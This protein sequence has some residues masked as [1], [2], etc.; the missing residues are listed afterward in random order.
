MVLSLGTGACRPRTSPSAPP[1]DG[2][3]C[4]AAPLEVAGPR[5][6]AALI[7]LRAR[8]LVALDAGAWHHA[9]RAFI[10]LL[11]A[12]PDDLSA[13][14]L[15]DAAT[16]AMLADQQ[17]SAAA[18]ATATA[19]VVPAPPDAAVVVRPAPVAGRGRAPRPALL[20]TTPA[21]TGD[22]EWLRA[23]CLALP[24]H[25]VPNPMRGDPGL[26]PPGTS[27][28]VGE[29]VLVQAIADGTRTI[30]LYGPDYRGA[31]F[32]VVQ[33]D[34][35]RL[36]F[37]DLAAWHDRGLVVTWAAHADGAVFVALGPRDADVRDAGFLAALDARTGEPLWRSPPHVVGA[38][39]FLVDGAHLLAADASRLVVLDRRTG[40]VV[41][42][43][44]IDG[45]P[46][47]LLLRGR[48]L[49]V[50]TSA[51]DLEFELR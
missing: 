22:D 23:H 25:A 42:E 33:A 29:H 5:L 35:G 24:E 51:V 7:E 11:A 8:G 39:N 16:R 37:L 46:Q 40:A 36:A 26:V 43:H 45:D 15:H 30:L 47:W 27:P 21:R 14:A 44:P 19:T 6:P 28:L 31:R 13:R 38:A 10:E 4:P 34:G 12:A 32:V 49:F 3:A 2:P 9:R 48:R 18:I 20:R 41:G 50:R 1:A 17:R